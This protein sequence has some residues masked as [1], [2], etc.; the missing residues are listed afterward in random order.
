MRRVSVCVG[1]IAAVTFVTAL[2][3]QPPAGGPPGGG[4]GRG[5]RGTPI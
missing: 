4:G 5:P 2:A 1:L 3:A